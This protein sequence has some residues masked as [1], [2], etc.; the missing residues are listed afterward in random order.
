MPPTTRRCAAG[1]PAPTTATRLPDPEPA[2]RALPRSRRRRALAHRRGHRRPGAR[3]APGRANRRPWGE[4]QAAA[5]A[6]GARRPERLHG[7]G[8]RGLAHALRAALS[9]ALAESGS[10]QQA[11]FSSLPGAAG[12]GRDGLPCRIG[13]YTDF[14]TGIHHATH[15]RQAVPPRQPAAAQLQVGAHRLPRPRPA[16]VVGGTPA[17]AQGP[18]QGRRATQRRCSAPAS[19]GLRAGAGCLRRRGPTRWASRCPSTRP[20]TRCSAWCCST[21]GRRATSRPGST[22]RWGPFL[23]KNFATTISPWIVTLEA[24]AP[25]RRPFTRPEATRSRCPTWTA[26]STARPVPRH[27]AG[28]AGCRPPPCARPAHPRCA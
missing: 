26:P 27:H 18:A 13:D 9:A 14:Y 12:A 4:V 8:P 17:P 6:A 10:A 23:A 20:R 16:S 11:P 15:H 19:A 24:L 21:T 28:G 5:G 1:W 22:S 3:P 7:P 2:V 25:F